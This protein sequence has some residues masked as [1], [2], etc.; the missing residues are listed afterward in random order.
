MLKLRVLKLITKLITPLLLAAGFASCQGSESGFAP[1]AAIKPVTSNIQATLLKNGSAQQ[2]ANG[3][4][5]QIDTADSV[6][7]SVTANGWK[8]EVKYE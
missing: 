6:T 1:S 8:I 7:N 2:T 5:L 4:N 3:W